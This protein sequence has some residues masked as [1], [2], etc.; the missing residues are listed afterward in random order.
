MRRLITLSIA[1]FALAACETIDGVGQDVQT[2]GTGIS[3][4][5]NAVEEDLSN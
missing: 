5:A 3:N 4:A 2:A 1:L